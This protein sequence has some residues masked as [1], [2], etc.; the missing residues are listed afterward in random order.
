MAARVNTLPFGSTLLI[1]A[2]PESTTYRN[3]LL[4]TAMLVGALNL[5]AAPWPSAKPETPYAPAKILE[6][7]LPRWY[8]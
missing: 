1:L 3:P 4:S 5:A 7:V 2:F 8:L 6:A